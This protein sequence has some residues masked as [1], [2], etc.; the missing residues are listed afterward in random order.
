MG[1]I[2]LLSADPIVGGETRLANP[3]QHSGFPA[4]RQ[5]MFITKS[6][7]YIVYEISKNICSSEIQNSAVLLA[8]IYQLFEGA[9][10][11][12]F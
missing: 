2:I 10:V 3:L 1:A 11:L 4:A 8:S 12:S 9:T 6:M 5:N 7:K